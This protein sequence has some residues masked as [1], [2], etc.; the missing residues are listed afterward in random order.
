MV[1]KSVSKETRTSL[2]LCLALFSLI[3]RGD[4]QE[5]RGEI[6]GLVIDSQNAVI[7]GASVAV[8]NVNTGAI[9]SLKT[10][11][12][13]YYEAG[14][15]IPGIYEI[16]VNADGFKKV[17][18]QGINLALGDRVRVNIPLEVGAVTE[19][20]T[21]SEEASLL[22]TTSTTAA[23]VMTNREVM[24][25]PVFNNSPVMLLKLTPGVIASSNRRYNGVN[26]LGG[27]SD[28]GLPG[29][30]GGTDWSIDGAPT[31][32]NGYSAA[33]LPYTTT[34]QEYKVE[35]A[36]FDAAHGKS[37]GI[38]VSV[39]TKPGT[40][41]LHGSANWQ[42]WNERWNAPRFF[43]KQQYYR[44]ISLAETAGD[45]QRANQLRSQPIQPPGHSNNYAGTVGGPLV[46]NKL[47]YFFTFDGFEDKKFVEGGFGRTIATPLNRTGDF[48]DL[49][50]VDAVRYT[51][52]DPLTVRADPARAGNFV[53]TPFPNNVL[54]Q[55]RI[56]NPGYTTYRDFL[57]APNNPPAPGRE[58]L[59]NY[60]A[61]NMPRDWHY[62]SYSNRMDYNASDRHRFYARWTWS[63]Y[64]EE[65]E[66]WTYETRPGLHT[67]G[68][69]RNYKAG[70]ANWAW[71]L[72]PQ[73]LVDATF[74]LSDF[75]EGNLFVVPFEYK[76]SAV[77]LPAYLDTKAGS[78]AV[79]PQMVVAGYQT[80]GQNVPAFTHFQLATG[81]L[82]FSHV[83]GRHT[84]RAG[85][86]RREHYRLGGAPGN[87]S[88]N[89]RF[90]N[91]FT[92]RYDDT[93]QPAG[94]LG[95]S[96][97]AFMMGLPAE[98]LV[99]TNDTF[100]MRNPYW[101]WYVQDKWRATSKLTL[102]FGLRIEWEGGR[103][104]RYNRVI[105]DFDPTLTLP[106]TGAAEAVYRASPI[107][108][109]PASSFRVIGGSTYPGVDGRDKSLQ[110]G[111]WM[112]MPRFGAAYQL[113]AKTVLRG[114]YGRYFDTIHTGLFGVDQTGFSRQTSS[115]V[116]NNF[117]VS[118]ALG[119]PVNGVSPLRDPFPVRADG[120]RF[121]QPVGNALGSMALVGRNWSY[122][123]STIRRARQHSWRVEVQRELAP[124]LLASL[125]Y[126]GLYADRTRV[127]RRVDPLPEQFWANGTVRDNALANNMNANVPNP[128]FIGNFAALQQ[129]SPLVY[130]N[131][132]S[133]SWFTSRT[134]R[135]NELLRAYPQMGNMTAT[136]DSVGAARSDSLEATMQR[137]F[138]AGYT[139]SFSYQGLRAVEKDFYFQE[140][141]PGPSEK[142][143]NQAV[144]H[145]YI[146]T[147]I[148]ELPFGRGKRWL[149]RGVSAALLG[150]WQIAQ[151]YEWQ[152]GALLAW[153]SPLFYYG[154][155][156][157]VA[158]GPRTLERWFNTDNFERNASRGPAAFHRRV[159]P[160]HIDGVRD[161]S[162][163]QWNANIQR[164]FGITEKVS[165]EFRFDMIN[166]A[167][168]S[169]FAAPN[170]DPYS[171]NFGRIT[172]HS[173]TTNRFVLV[174][175]RILF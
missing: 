3:Q 155:P 25:L 90:A 20:I 19:S 157:D 35:T 82:N 139:F 140:Y 161:D 57:P 159:F 66:D 5:T 165:F 133:S 69:N 122:N 113:D 141:D 27:L 64:R 23:R 49:L 105:N 50:A 91:D 22:A 116:T 60:Q 100:A 92:R 78:N 7:P 4:A 168:H 118:W 55:S 14:L 136:N 123:P 125:A 33:Y 43:L 106:I 11:E 144:P 86:D 81:K 48:R 131:M 12:T 38:S 75:E 120:S 167:N 101:G 79:L 108:E 31:T 112:W 65:Q 135:K 74:S 169:Q 39:I 150:G 130:Q 147:G 9:V 63:K 109:L 174:Q 138:A 10:N 72:T 111:E 68:V 8:R 145:R 143:S 21:V 70:I 37:T 84:V 24:S 146:A 172:A 142:A 96:W 73:T 173:S 153:S 132:A 166:V 1:R 163:N 17:V 114:G 52:H 126:H 137:R 46:K 154:D 127:A 164:K 115:I 94:N 6:V 87:T 98:V 95:H 47:F 58:P 71:T 42:Y 89:F 134:I 99:D 170:I 59:E 156:A 13:G 148:Y 83:R 16:T 77:G 18:R 36:N 124:N 32:G 30:I 15:L 129:S 149:Q 152:A 128:F 67:T 103:Y 85:F 162:L 61:T 158:K 160:N 44:N 28:A 117:G 119:D 26:A 151:T 121:D 56:A 93:L 40:N 97:A 45:T 88:G 107:P 41:Q 80:M 110:P 53:R 104:E 54:P 76:P 175:G 2:A 34:I 29:G 62:K 102:H 51:I 171:T